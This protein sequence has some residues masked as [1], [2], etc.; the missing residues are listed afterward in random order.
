MVSFYTSPQFVE[1]E[2]RLTTSFSESTFPSLSAVN[3]FIEEES[4]WLD[5]LTNDVF[6]A[7]VV[8]S[9][10]FD[11]DGSGL[12]RFPKHD[13]RSIQKFEYNCSARGITPSWIELEEGHDKNFLLYSDEGEVE[14]VIGA[15]VSN[16]LGKPMAGKKKFRISYTY[17]VS[18][19]PSDVVKLA[20][21]LVTKRILTT[22][23]NSQANTGGGSVS[24]GTIRITEP[25]NYSINYYKSM[26]EDIDL[27]VKN[28]GGSNKTFRL[29]RVY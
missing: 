12:F 13:V 3:R 17:G 9:E 26:N 19:T 15:N 7:N 5:R 28:L 16:F 2:L 8:T 22:L 11:Y 6:S 1:Q 24:V 27:L 18:T 10:Y 25:G 29:T 20:T 14:F 23:N 4:A 21:L